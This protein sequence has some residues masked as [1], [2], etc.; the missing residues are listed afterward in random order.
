MPR[1]INLRQIVINSDPS[2]VVPVRQ[3]GLVGGIIPTCG[4]CHGFA[5]LS[6]TA[7]IELEPK[8]MSEVTKIL[9]QIQQGTS[10]QRPNCCRWCMQNCADWQDTR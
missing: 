10:R 2:R 4:K 9:D 1:F 6:S 7:T 5:S 8:R 3:R